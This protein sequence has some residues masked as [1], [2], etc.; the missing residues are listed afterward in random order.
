VVTWGNHEVDA[1]QNQELFLKELNRDF[2]RIHTLLDQTIT[3]KGLKIHGS[4]ISPAF[5]NWAY[6]RNPGPDIQKHWDLIPTD[7]D[8]LITHCPPWNT[9]D[10]VWNRQNEP[11]GC[12]DL[13]NT[14]DLRLTKLKLH[15]FGH[16]HSGNGMLKYEKIKYVN[17][18]SLNEEYKVAYQPRVVIL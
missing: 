7:V 15:V 16:I 5:R 17:A 10:K 9:L 8:V 2:P 11:L 12:K 18:S 3:I 4:P 6:N 14:I 13:R 1:E